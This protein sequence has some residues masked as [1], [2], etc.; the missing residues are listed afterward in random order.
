[1]VEEPA[2]A[3]LLGRVDKDVAVER[4]E[5]EVLD[6]LVAV[7]LHLGLERL[8][9]DHLADVLVHERVSASTKRGRSVSAE[10]GRSLGERPRERGRERGR[11]HAGMSASARTP[12]PF[13]S[14]LTTSIGAYSRFW[15]L[16][17]RKSS[18]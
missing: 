17:A 15:N 8:G 11:T 3:A 7:R 10:P 1:V 14:V 16:R 18:S 9:P 13:F 5:V 4:H 6:A 12:K 2:L